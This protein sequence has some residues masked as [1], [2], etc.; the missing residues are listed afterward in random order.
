MSPR[1]ARQL[2]A[3]EAARILSEEGRRDHLAAKRKAALRLGLSRRHLPTNREIETALA[4]RQRLFEA[5]AQKRRLKRLRQAAL[6]AMEAFANFET[7]VAG[8]ALNG[9]A[10]AYA[11]VK[12]HVFTDTPEA[13]VFRLGE[14]GF[15]WN[16]STRRLRWCS[17]R[18]RDIP[19]FTFAI[20]GQTVEAYVFSLTEL[21]EAPADPVDGRP[22]PR[23]SRR[24][25]EAT[26]A[27]AS[28]AVP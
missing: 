18:Q 27:A 15:A 16:E 11:P 22:M 12:L 5:P 26:R 9:V 1:Q 7:R 21:R 13:V 10:T 8:A 25:L 24:R 17:G 23:I 19:V 3:E 2:V 4:E 6:A 20:G 28:Q 14:R